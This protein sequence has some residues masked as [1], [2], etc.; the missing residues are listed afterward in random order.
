[1]KSRNTTT[2]LILI[3]LA[4]VALSYAVLAAAQEEGIVYPVTELGDCKDKTACM[5]YCDAPA[6]YRA[7]FLFARAHN[8]LDEQLQ[9]KSE[10]DIERFADAMAGG[11]PGG[12]A[13]QDTCHFYCSAVD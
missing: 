2:A 11:G 7:C 1:M 13:S 10:E 5:Q 8:L 6:N 9:A 12:C 4:A 3:S